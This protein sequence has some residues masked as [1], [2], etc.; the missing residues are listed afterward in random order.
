MYK[1]MY[2][3]I[4][5][6]V[7]LP[8]ANNFLVHTHSHAPI[9]RFSLAAFQSANAGCCPAVVSCKLD[10]FWPGCRT[11]NRILAALNMNS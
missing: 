8:K 4:F 1:Y 11:D 3:G 7:N 2:A 10:F 9:G 5:D 6:N